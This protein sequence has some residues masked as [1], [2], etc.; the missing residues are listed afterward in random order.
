MADMPLTDTPP[1]HELQP[2]P[3]PYTASTAFLLSPSHSYVLTVLAL[4]L[5]V[6]VLAV[7]LLVF[8]LC[9]RCLCFVSVCIVLCVKV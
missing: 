2:E 3:H 6:L 5:A 4:V 9:R 7:L 1:G 8:V